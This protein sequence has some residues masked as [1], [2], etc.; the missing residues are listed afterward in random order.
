[1]VDGASLLAAMFYGLLHAN[2][3]E[4]ARGANVLDT[5]APWYNVYETKDGK[6]VSVGAI[7]A[8][9]FDELAGRLDL[10]GLA[11]H[12]RGRWPEMAQ[13]FGTIFKSKTRDEWVR[14]FEGSDACFATVLG[15]SEAPRHAHNRSRQ[16]HVTVNRIEQPAPAPRF[17]RTPGEV[18]RPPPERGEGG[19]EALE[20]W[21]FGVDEIERMKSR[22]FGFKS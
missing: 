21:G 10:N 5:G 11:Q 14:I 19:A 7:E 8:R 6:Y 20:D 17:S 18:L 4:E 3:I 15:W 12:D 13:Q 22:G 1:M 9:F 16:A 2:Q